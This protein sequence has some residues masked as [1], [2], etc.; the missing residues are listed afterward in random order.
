MSPAPGSI[1][2]AAVSS[3]RSCPSSRSRAW[4]RP[5]ILRSWPSCVPAHSCR[6]PGCLRADARA[7][8][9]RRP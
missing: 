6:R 2:V 3:S 1:R 7:P 4:S 9:R 5:T 8:A